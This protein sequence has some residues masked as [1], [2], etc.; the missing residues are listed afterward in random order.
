MN[1]RIASLACALALA[2]TG[3]DAG[4]DSESRRLPAERNL[5]T[6]H[7]ARAA[8]GAVNVVVEIPAG[9]NAK[10]ETAKDGE[11]LVWEFEDG[12]PRVVRYLPYPA[13]YGMVPGTRLA[14]DEG[15]DGDPLDVVLL[16]PAR[17]RGTVVAGRLVGV[18]RL[19]DGGEQDD[20]LLAVDLSGPLGGVGELAEL[21]RDFPGVAQILET[22][23][24]HYK[25]PGRIE[26]RGFGDR[27]EASAILERAE[28]TFRE[29]ESTPATEPRA[30]SGAGS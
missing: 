23:F 8:D 7:P 5:L 29:R 1:R 14:L 10:W 20:K 12:R 24:A 9:T 2:L 11:G 15:G 16:G 18:L 21:E 28:R 13:N 4:A 6:G 3:A 19:L 17:A 26:T 22:W 25:G 30:P 27:A